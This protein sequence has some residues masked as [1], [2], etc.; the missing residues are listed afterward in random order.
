MCSG[1]KQVVLIVLVWT[2][3]E[4]DDTVTQWTSD[5]LNSYKVPGIILLQAYIYTYSLLRGATLEVLPLTSYALSPMMLLLLE[6]F[7]ELLLWNSFQRRH[8]F[9]IILKSSSL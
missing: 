8:I 4:A 9:F 2:Y 7:L 1:N 5:T 6:T 3:K